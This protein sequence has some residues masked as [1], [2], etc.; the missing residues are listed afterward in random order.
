MR[1]NLPRTS[2]KR[3]VLIKPDSLRKNAKLNQRW[4]KIARIVAF[5]IVVA[6][7]LFVYSVRDQAAKL[8]IYG[9]PGIFLISFLAYATVLIP[10][11]GIAVVFAMGAIFN[12]IGVA[13]AAGSGA[14]LG[15][16]VGYLAGFSGQ[17]VVE[18]ADIYEK[19]A[20][21]MQKNGSLTVFLLA[22]VPNPFFDLAGLVAG[23]LK[24]QYRKFLFWCWCGQCVKMLFFAYAGAT[25]IDSLLSRIFS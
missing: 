25:S 12:P 3:K 1:K 7:T 10:A 17:G 9:Y 21:W 19:F 16:T 6:I 2:K 24:M 20:S 13:L 5:I 14:A 8:A 18:R 15:E 11:P 22:A 23:A 4:L